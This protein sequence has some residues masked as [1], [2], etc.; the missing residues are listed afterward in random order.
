MKPKPRTTARAHDPY[1][2]FGYSNYR[3]YTLG[4]FLSV[5]G[6]QML[7]VAVN[8]EVYHQTHSVLASGLIGLFIWIPIFLFMLPG[9][10]LADRF[11]RKLLVLVC[12][13]L[14][15]VCAIGLAMVVHFSQPV[16]LIFAFLFLIGVARAFSDPPKNALLP[17]L[18]PQKHFTNAIAWNSNIFQIASVAGPALGGW[19]YSWLGFSNVC[20]IDVSIEAV[21]FVLILTVRQSIKYKKEPISLDS[22]L[23]GLKFVRDNKLILATITMDL[24][25]VI[26]GGATALFPA[27]DDKVLHCGALGVGLLSTAIAM[28]AF[29]T[30]FLVAHLPMK[31]AG[32]TL[33][34][35]VAGFGVVTIVFGLSHWYWLSFL[36]MFLAGAFDNISVIVRHTLVQVL[37]PNTMRGRI[38]SVSYI[39][40]HSSNELGGFESGAVAALLGLI[41]SVIVGGVGSLL[42]VLAVNKIWPEVGRIKSLSKVRV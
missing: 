6:Q 5:L 20:W 42:V 37:T 21:F 11:N 2:A 15:A 22:L 7:R 3:Y 14:F 38:T 17:E 30:S 31:R 19:F 29:A 16:S 33:L 41:P 32:Q 18:V 25:A 1:A 34:W 8:Y 12:N 28:G 39:F 23:Q 13:L 36:M 24:F 35:A 27:F 4:N 10:M 26:L 40:I 9:G